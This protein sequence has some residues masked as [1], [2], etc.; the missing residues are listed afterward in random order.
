MSHLWMQTLRRASYRGVHFWVERDQVDTGRRLVVHEFPL[1]DDPY[2]EDMGRQA[3]KVQVTAYVVG[4]GAGA[5]AADLRR[6]CDAGGAAAL[7][8]PL[9][10]FTAHCDKCSR[11]FAKDKLGFVAF[12]LNFVLEG[13]G[14]A[15]FPSSFLARMAAVA[16]PPLAAAAISLLRTGYAALGH[17][18]WVAAEGAEEIV[19]IAGAV[20]VA[21]LELTLTPAIGTRL[22]AEIRDTI[23]MAPQ[24]AA[25]GDTGDR[26]RQRDFMNRARIVDPGVI[27]ERVFAHMTA[28]QEGGQPAD[29]VRSLESLTQWDR[30]AA[31]RSTAQRSRS[32]NRAWTNRRALSQVTRLAAIT[33]SV[34]AMIER[35][36]ADRR[37]AIQARADI[38]ELIDREMLDLDGPAQH[39]AHVALAEL[40]RRSIE[41]LSREIIDLKPIRIVDTGA[42]LPSLYWA[43]VMYGSA[44]RAGELAALNGTFHPGFMSQRFEA[45]L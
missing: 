32:A 36:Y 45:R 43:Q 28:L 37:S 20:D 14:A 19:G 13:S 40:R 2:V 26:W 6:A 39:E 4:E 38:A 24:L 41:Y 22:A 18:S 30:D 5:E 7:V 35:D 8:L 3:N 10:R 44:D 34:V 42:V 1:R 17:A 21:R 33:A 15:P 12:S 9:E 16:G 31:P 27:A 25:S 11:D 23:R 29:V